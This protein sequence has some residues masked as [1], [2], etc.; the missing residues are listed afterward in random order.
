MFRRRR[1]KLVDPWTIKV[2]T[3][4]RYD[5]AGSVVLWVVDERSMNHSKDNK[6]GDPWEGVDRW[7]RTIKIGS[8]QHEVPE[9][10]KHNVKVP[11]P[12]FTQELADLRSLAEDRAAALNIQ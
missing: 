1:Q 2:T 5:D 12:N 4:A 6:Y 7:D 9:E 3:T 10:G 11:N 8:V